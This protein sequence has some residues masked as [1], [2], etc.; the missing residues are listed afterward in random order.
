M[1]RHVLVCDD[2][3]AVD[4]EPLD[5]VRHHAVHGLAAEVVD[6]LLDQ[7][8]DLVVLLAGLEAA[9]DDLGRGLGSDDSISLLAGDLLRPHNDGRRHKGNVA[10][11]VHAQVDLRDVAL[12]KLH[13]LLLEGGEVAAAVVERDAGGEGDALLNLLPLVHGRELLVDRG[14]ARLA[15]LSDRLAHHA[16]RLHSLDGGVGDIARELVLVDDL[17]V[18][19][20]ELLLLVILELLLRVRHLF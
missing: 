11:N 8:G 20:I 15:Q 18:A 7:G 13:A 1:A 6:R 12:L 17:R 2:L 9:D 14:V 5:L 16:S 3:G 19:A 4:G 10:I